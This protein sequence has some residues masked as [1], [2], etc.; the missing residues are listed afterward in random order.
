M[1]HWGLNGGELSPPDKR[2]CC[3]RGIH[4]CRK[5]CMSFISA[6]CWWHHCG[7]ASRLSSANFVVPLC[8]STSRREKLKR[9]LT[10]DVQI[11]GLADISPHVVADSAQVEAAV[12]LQH[13]FDEQRAVHQN[14]DPKA[15]VQSDGFELRNASSWGRK[16]RCGTS[17]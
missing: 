9:V 10:F 3:F 8:K 12:L 11:H 5:F 13:M 4:P 17:E 16:H 15:R 6:S 2:L 14:L 7:R 1:Q